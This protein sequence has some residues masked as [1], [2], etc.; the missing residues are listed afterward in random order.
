[1]KAVHDR[2]GLQAPQK[3]VSEIVHHD[4]SP[5]GLEGVVRLDYAVDLSEPSLHLPVGQAAR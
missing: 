2:L 5:G 4:A 3:I 1:M